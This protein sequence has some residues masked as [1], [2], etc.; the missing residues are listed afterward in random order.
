MHPNETSAADEALV[1]FGS[2][3]STAKIDELRARLARAEA[4]RDV[5]KLSPLTPDPDLTRR[6]QVV[7]QERAQIEQE[8]GHTTTA[9]ESASRDLTAQLQSK[10]E[11]LARLARSLTERRKDLDRAAIRAAHYQDLAKMYSA[12]LARGTITAAEYRE[13]QKSQREAETEVASLT[14]EL[15]DGQSEK[16]LLQQHV[17]KLE[18]TKIDPKSALPVQVETMQGRLL[19]LRQQEEKLKAALELDAARTVKLRDAELSQAAAKIRECEAGIQAMS[20]GHEARA[21]FSG[22]VAYRAP[23]PNAVRP[24]GALL[25]VGPEN[26]FLLTARMPRSEAAYLQAGSVV[27]LEVAGDTPERKVPARFVRTQDLV[28]EPG[29]ASI[30][31]ECQPPPEVVRRLAEGEKLTVAFSWSPPL[32]DLWPFQGGIALVL[33]GGL[34]LILPRVKRPAANS[35]ALALWRMLVPSAASQHAREILNRVPAKSTT[36]ASLTDLVSRPMNR[37]ERVETADTQGL[38][39]ELEELCRQVVER[40][41]VAETPEQ[42]TDDVAANLRAA[43]LAFPSTSGENTTYRFDSVLSVF[44]IFDELKSG[45]ELFSRFLGATEA[46]SLKQTFDLSGEK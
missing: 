40:V 45:A 36:I 23:S 26:G 39:D 19:A 11:T 33:V 15:K 43:D 42:A 4:E 1:R 30:Q 46:K 24:G 38:A 20:G 32:V 37:N 17:V 13:N 22:R 2:R 25:V 18:A 5:L 41:N 14:Q 27:T 34:G 21:P 12:L 3:P 10:K 29:Q 35:S 44:E 16:A 7:A 8:L 9:S 6:H 31:M 28:H